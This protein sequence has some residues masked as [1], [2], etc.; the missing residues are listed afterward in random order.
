MSGE[1]QSFTKKSGGRAKQKLQ[2]PQHQ[3]CATGTGLRILRRGADWR[4]LPGD[5]MAW[6]IIAEDQS[7]AAALR[8]D[9][10]LMARMWE[11]ELSHRE[12]ILAAG[13]LRTDD[14][15]TPVGSLMVLD[16]ATRAEAEA[17]WATDPATIAGMRQPPVIRFWNPAILNREV[18]P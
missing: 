2:G 18:M 8:Q 10:A 6:L 7:G 1:K 5:A 4:K 12:R 3:A 14:G 17:I 16:V 9:K 15:G 11:W 13:S